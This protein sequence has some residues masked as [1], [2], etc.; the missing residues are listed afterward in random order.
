MFVNFTWVHNNMMPVFIYSR[1]FGRLVCC[2]GPLSPDGT[3]H[4]H[5]QP[6]L[7][8]KLSPSFLVLCKLDKIQLFLRPG[9]RGIFSDFPRLVHTR[10]LAVRRSDGLFTCRRRSDWRMACGERRRDDVRAMATC[11][12]LHQ[13]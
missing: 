8:N 6:G 1:S 13:D 9:P 12:Q 5:W 10:Y 11:Q 3:G 2:E 4:L 7:Q